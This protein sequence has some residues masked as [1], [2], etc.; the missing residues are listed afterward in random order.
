MI[1]DQWVLTSADCVCNAGNTSNL[2]VR[3]NGICDTTKKEIGHGY[4]VVDI[5]CFSRHIPTVLN[6]NLTLININTSGMISKQHVVHLI[7]LANNKFNIEVGEQVMLFS[8]K[9]L[10]AHLSKCQMP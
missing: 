9:I 7:C 1:S 10:W 8:W 5:K 2:E 4:P 3:I 6:T